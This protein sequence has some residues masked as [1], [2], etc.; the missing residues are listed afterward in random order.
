MLTI[1]AISLG[2]LFEGSGRITLLFL[3]TV[4]QEPLRA[5]GNINQGVITFAKEEAQ[6]CRKDPTL[7]S[8]TDRLRGLLSSKSCYKTTRLSRGVKNNQPKARIPVE[9]IIQLVN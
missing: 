5:H 2:S 6:G 9:I 7:N 3:E 1:T 8:C 4:G